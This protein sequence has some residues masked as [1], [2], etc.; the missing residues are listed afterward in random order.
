MRRSSFIK[1][2]K[3]SEHAKLTLLHSGAGYGKSS[4]LS[5]YYR[6]TGPLHSWY[7]VTEEDDDILPFITYLRNVLQRIYSNLVSH[8]MVGKCVGCTQKKKTSI[9]GLLYS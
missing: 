3:I 7:S 2:M 9:D 5:C 1:K 8:L 6:D 4:S